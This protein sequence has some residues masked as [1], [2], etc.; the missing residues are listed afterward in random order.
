L[1]GA[2]SI[3]RQMGRVED[4]PRFG[5]RPID[6][7]MLFYDD[8]VLTTPDLIIPHPRLHQRGF[9]LFPLHEIARDLLHPGLGMTVAQLLQKAQSLEK[10]HLYKV[11]DAQANS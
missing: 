9:T 8:L 6:I 11:K 5:P 3:E 7:D 4:G 1:H 10:V 2:K